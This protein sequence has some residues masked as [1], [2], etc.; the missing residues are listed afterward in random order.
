MIEVTENA[1]KAIESFFEEKKIVS[2]L[3][4]FIQSGG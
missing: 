1:K 3:R 4:V 2:A